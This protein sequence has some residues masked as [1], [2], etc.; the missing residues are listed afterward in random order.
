VEQNYMH[1]ETEESPNSEK[2]RYSLVYNILCSCISKACRLHLLGELLSVFYG[3]KTWC[4]IKVTR[5]FEK[6]AWRGTS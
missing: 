2:A 1:Q 6:Y 4:L 5:R 3:Y